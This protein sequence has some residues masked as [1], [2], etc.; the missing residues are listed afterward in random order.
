[1]SFDLR[2]SKFIMIVRG[3]QVEL[4]SVRMCYVWTH[5]ILCR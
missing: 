2:V 5:P 3:F 1:M 4:W